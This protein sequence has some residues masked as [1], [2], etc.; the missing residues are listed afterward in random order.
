MEA[1]VSIWV[2]NSK[3]AA[4]SCE[5]NLSGQ[6]SAVKPLALGE[7]R[8]QAL[9]D[10]SFDAILLM[11]PGG[12]IVLAN[13]TACRL[14]GYT[15]QELTKIDWR[16]IVVI[17]S[18]AAAA[19]NDFEAL[20]RATAELTFRR[21]DGST[22]EGEFTAAV[23]TEP[24]GEKS[25]SV[26]IRDV[27]NR[28]RVEQKLKESSQKIR[29][30][31]EKLR[32]VGSL[33]RHD[34]R[35]KLSIINANVYLLKKR[36]GTDPELTKYLDA[37]AAA[38][39]SSDKLFEFSRLYEKI[40][41]EELTQI[42]VG[43]CFNDAT[44]LAPNLAGINVVNECQGLVVMAD[45]L[46][47]QLFYNLIDN[48]IKHGHNVKQIRVYYTRSESGVKVFYED[49]GIGIPDEN[50]PYLFTDGFTTDNGSGLGLKLA[51]RMVDVYGWSI[52]E[53]GT[54][55]KGVRFE[56]TIPNAT[57]QGK[58]LSGFS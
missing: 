30:M 15:N 4:V 18:C 29:A 50:K 12:Q 2:L 52:R 42:N 8:F 26:I 57:A 14:F 35:N 3:A 11:K 6:S 39:A 17:D 55:S 32:V 46:L 43:A 53:I 44:E 31:N 34:V 48:S 49:D 10:N 16:S 37:I 51:K 5:H 23:F 56:I 27:S 40:G 7:A 20:S 9:F 21:K 28:R 36:I 1:L 25:I 58:M 24:N 45:S 33:I 38:V 22:F 54:P 47:R 19:A 41:A 13:A